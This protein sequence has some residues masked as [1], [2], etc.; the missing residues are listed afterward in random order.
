VSDQ[1][2]SCDIP[3]WPAGYRERC[4]L[5]L[6]D[7]ECPRHGLR[8]GGGAARD[9]IQDYYRRKG[10]PGRGTRDGFYQYEVAQLT[11]LLCRLEVIL[12]DEGV[13]GDTRRRVIRAMLYASPSEAEA[14]YRMTQERE[15]IEMLKERPLSM[16]VT[17][18][19]PSALAKLGLPPQ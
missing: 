1:P 6:S 7:G 13:D 3:V 18:L 8:R 2:E 10:Q 15:M 11:D 16:H 9:L 4:D 12:D 17:G 14:E 19:D 5:H